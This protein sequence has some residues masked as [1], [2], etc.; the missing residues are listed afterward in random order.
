VSR[1]SG[2]ALNVIGFSF[3]SFGL[4]MLVF[5]AAYARD[6]VTLANGAF[7]VWSALCGQPIESDLTLPLLFSMSLVAL[8]AGAIVLVVRFARR[9]KMA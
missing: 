4:T 8:L 2:F 1:N 5:S 9:S 6:L 3:I 7:A